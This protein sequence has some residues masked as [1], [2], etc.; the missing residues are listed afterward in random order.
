VRIG[1]VQKQ[2]P[3]DPK[4][5]YRFPEVKRFGKIDIYQRLGMCDLSWGCD[6][7]ETHKCKAVGDTGDT[8]IH[9][10]VS[11]SRLKGSTIKSGDILEVA[12]AKSAKSAA[13]AKSSQ[14]IQEQ[15]IEGMLTAAMKSLLKTMPD[16]AA[17][18]LCDFI[19]KNYRNNTSIR[20]P[21]VLTEGKFEPYY[22]NFVLPSCGQAYFTAFH[23]RF[24]PQKPRA[25]GAAK[26]EGSVAEL[27][28]TVESLS[29]KIEQLELEASRA[30]QAASPDAELL[31]ARA[32][33]AEAKNAELAA[34]VE[35][36]RQQIRQLEQAAGK[37]HEDAVRQKAKAALLAASEDGVM[38]DKMT[39]VAKAKAD[40]DA[41]EKAKAA[42]LAHVNLQ[43][44]TL[45]DVL[46]AQARADAPGRSQVQPRSEGDRQPWAYAP[47]VA[48]WANP[49]P[50]PRALR[51]QQLTKPQ[52]KEIDGLRR[53]A[54][55]MFYKASVEGSLQETLETV[56][57]G[58][59][60]KVLDKLRDQ[61]RNALIDASTSGKL[62]GLLNDV[63]RPLAEDGTSADPLENIRN[64]ALHLL[65]RA[66]ADG[67]LM[68]ILQEAHGESRDAARERWQHKPSVGAW[69]ATV[70]AKP[71][72]LK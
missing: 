28:A 69:L 60:D 68:Q 49:A 63:G 20:K 40:A 36:Q 14:Y 34:T 3:Y 47:S 5:L 44:G 59:S 50:M 72:C 70:P 52:S 2:A 61:T 54:A 37:A 4:T 56:R 38:L 53:R 27:T 46:N 12:T 66:S 45:L 65:T 32:E 71:S 42:L 13:A 22:R 58:S 24:F 17:A 7:Q 41:R 25:A 29:R 33:R 55:D 30:R 31:R 64:N 1:N 6:D 39:R 16:D 23:R 48:S 19:S 62:D 35:K 26:A 67:S 57:A 15:H 10:Q 43:E 9:L 8:G 51:K 11:M 18:F 21:L